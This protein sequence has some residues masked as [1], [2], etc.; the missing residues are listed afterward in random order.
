MRIQK[1]LYCLFFMQIIALLSGSHAAHPSQN[2]K[3]ELQDQA[4]L[5]AFKKR[6]QNLEELIMCLGIN[7]QNVKKTKCKRNL[8]VLRKN[9]PKLNEH[10]ADA[11]VD[12]N[13]TIASMQDKDTKKSVQSIFD[14]HKA[15]SEALQKESAELKL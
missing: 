2:E 13:Q 15:K 6:M 4:Q 5:H 14:Q 11:Q 10:L 1:I 7:M 12:V 8:N 3:T 9:M